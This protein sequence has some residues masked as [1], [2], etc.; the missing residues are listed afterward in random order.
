MF[1]VKERNEIVL[2]KRGI[3]PNKKKEETIDPSKPLMM[4]TTLLSIDAIG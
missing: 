4:T 2:N 1:N 3:G